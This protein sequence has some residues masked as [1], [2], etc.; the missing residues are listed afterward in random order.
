MPHPV[1]LPRALGEAFTVTEAAAAGVTP[2][3]LRAADLS[4]PFV[5]ARSVGAPQTTRDRCR[6]LAPLLTGRQ[7]FSHLT[8]ADLLGLRLP[9]RHD[10]AS[11]HVTS[12]G[13]HRSM[14]RAGVVGHK[15]SSDAAIDDI[16]GLLVSSPLQAWRECAT[17]LEVDDL[18]VMG[19]GLV[20]RRNPFVTLDQLAASVAHGGEVRGIARLRRALE[21]IRPG[22]DSA[23]E[24]MLRL[25]VARAG[26]EEPIPNHPLTDRN[27][28]RIG[29]GDLVWPSRRVVLEYEGRQH[30]ENARQFGID[31]RR[32]DDI[33][34]AGYRVVRVDARMMSNPAD[35]VRRLA[36][37]LEGSRPA[38]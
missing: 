2:R 25:L 3:R 13:A 19:D 17:L 20:S 9:E 27:G 34:A 14:R 30:A 22:T 12:I 7:Y 5:G 29:H 15:T 18:V 23:R 16:G 21:L 31:I 4:H 36:A 35:L 38:G 28:A 26:C 11:L 10:R 8:A 32:L 33:A 1:A 24:T 37:A 6:A